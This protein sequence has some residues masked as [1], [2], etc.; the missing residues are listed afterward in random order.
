MKVSAIVCV[1]VFLAFFV[2][3]FLPIDREAVLLL[4]AFALFFLLAAAYQLTII[5]VDYERKK[6]Q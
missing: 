3:M 1:L 6:R 2:S 4:G 5:A